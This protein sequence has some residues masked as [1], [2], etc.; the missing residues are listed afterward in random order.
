MSFLLFLKQTVKKPSVIVMLFAVLTC[1][2]L[3]GML[4]NDDGFP[5]CGVVSGEDENAKLVANQLESDGLIRYENADALKKGLRRGEVASG[6]VFPDDFTKRLEDANTEELLTFYEAPASVF[7]SLFKF[8]TAAYIM[9]VYAPYIISKLMKYEGANIPHEE[10]RDAIADYIAS[11][12]PF[13]FTFENAEG[14]KLDVNHYSY[15]LSAGVVALFLFFAFGLFALPYTEKQF[16]GIAR[17]IGL[18]K[19]CLSFMLPSALC[20]ILLFSS[21]SVASVWLSDILFMSGTRKLAFAAVIY[22]FYLSALTIAVTAIF[23]STEKVRVP[24]IAIC[25]LSL[26]L[27]PIFIDVPALFGIPEWC[28]YV[29]P[30]MFFYA[31]LESPLVCGIIAATAFVCATVFYFIFYK[32]KMHFA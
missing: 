15:N 12:N 4:K 16:L 10:M 24:I 7:P 11:D 17:R 19:A 31:A 3:C 21:V 26:A 14:A 5:N 22:T 30:T 20:I 6:I 25:L 13:E 2:L 27:C 1:V 9:D 18:K 29:L 23:G 32:K 28:L 8:R